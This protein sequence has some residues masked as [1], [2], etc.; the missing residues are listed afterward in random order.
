MSEDGLNRKAFEGTASFHKTIHEDFMMAYL[1]GDWTDS[2]D[3]SWTFGYKEKDGAP[4]YQYAALLANGDYHESDPGYGPW[5]HYAGDG[6]YG[7]LEPSFDGASTIYK[8]TDLGENSM[9]MRDDVGEIVMT[10][11]WSLF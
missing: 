6:I 10:R 5:A 9:T 4:Y 11:A 3:N 2:A 1:T 8:I 7:S